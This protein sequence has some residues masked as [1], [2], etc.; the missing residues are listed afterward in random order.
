LSEERTN[1]KLPKGGGRK[2]I[3]IA[4]FLCAIVLLVPMLVIELEYRSF[5]SEYGDIKEGAAGAGL[6]LAVIFRTVSRTVLRTIIRTS[7][8]AGMRASLKGAIKNSAR[9]AARTQGKKLSKLLRLGSDEESELDV[10]KIKAKNFKS[11]LF[12]S[13]LLYV[14]WIVV[15][16]FGQPYSNLLDQHDSVVILE[17]TSKQNRQLMLANLDLAIAAHEAE[18]ETLDEREKLGELKTR[19]K[20]E[21]D[22]TK[23]AE[24][25]E[26]MALQAA[27]VAHAV[28][29]ERTAKDASGDQTFNPKDALLE[30]DS[31]VQIV[32]RAI[33]SYSRVQRWD[34]SVLTSV[35]NIVGNYLDSEVELQQRIWKNNTQR[36][37][38]E[39]EFVQLDIQLEASLRSN[40]S[41]Q[42]AQRVQAFIND[43]ANLSFLPIL[44]WLKTYPPFP[45]GKLESQKDELGKDQ[46]VIKRGTTEWSSLVLW[47][48]GI[49]VVLPLW[50]MYLAQWV[51]A[52]R[53]N[54]IL[55]HETGVDGGIIQLY[56]AGAFSF[57][58]LTS[59]VIVDCSE[60]VRSRI[61]L[62][63]IFTTSVIAVLLWFFGKMFGS[64]LFIFGAEAFM[65]YPMVQCFPL[66]PLEGG[67][68]WS[69]DKRIWLVM[70]VIIMAMFMLLASEGLN[71][72]I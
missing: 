42:D 30:H 13:V 62:S 6:L 56:F 17:Q 31:Q 55:R 59:D 21:R 28:E 49:V 2:E 70:F 35:E 32:Q 66:R 72:V 51:S 5:I 16:G 33:R 57:M 38:A 3:I 7:A 34:K 23:Q 52:R 50:V 18:L 69:Y 68:V 67:F 39:R 64:N 48:G 10:K 65:L 45:A 36:E 44:D 15:I 63:G 58:P 61:A 27:L 20:N 8:R 24:I 25:Q 47:L 60:K 14:S 41:E 37:S 43:R 9:A 12:A 46:M 4:A 1:R 26:Q 40:L 29:E 19:L 53:H 11:L 71:N 22:L 54:Q